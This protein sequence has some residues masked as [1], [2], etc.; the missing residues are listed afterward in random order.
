VIAGDTVGKGF[1]RADNERRDS[2]VFRVGGE[3]ALE[4][5]HLFT[6]E[7]IGR[8]TVE[9]NEVN[10][11]ALPVIVGVQAMVF[12]VVAKALLLNFRSIEPVRK[13]SQIVAAIFRR[14]KFVIANR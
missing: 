13:L 10:S 1:V 8:G 11:A 6:V 14:D 3:D 7:L 5:C 9:R 4:P 12:W 2:G